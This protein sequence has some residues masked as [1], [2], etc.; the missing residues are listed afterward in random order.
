M[1]SSEKNRFESHYKVLRQHFGIDHLPYAPKND[2]TKGEYFKRIKDDKLI[3]VKPIT[4]EDLDTAISL[5]DFFD[6][7]DNMTS[8]EFN[9]ALL[10]KYG[11][12]L[13]IERDV[14]EIETLKVLRDIDLYNKMVSP[15]DRNVKTMRDILVFFFV[16]W[17]I[18][19]VIMVWAIF[20]VF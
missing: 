12:A 6:Q 5:S 17:L 3:I 9:K 14:R 11:Y 13:N 20:S 2:E 8:E 19:S 18:S 4:D 10:D 15:I 16:L 1:N 7:R